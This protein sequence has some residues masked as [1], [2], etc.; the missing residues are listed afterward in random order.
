MIIL[1]VGKVQ[2][3]KHLSKSVENVPSVVEMTACLFHS[4]EI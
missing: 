1:V 3:E 2:R 4:Y